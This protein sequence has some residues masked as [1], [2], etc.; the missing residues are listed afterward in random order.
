MKV[1]GGDDKSLKIL[2]MKDR[3]YLTL[4]LPIQCMISYLIMAAYACIKTVAAGGHKL[5]VPLVMFATK[6]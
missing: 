4:L 1:C 3:K 5:T 2:S 6:D